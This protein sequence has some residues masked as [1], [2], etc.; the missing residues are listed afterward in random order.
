M[1]E[2]LVIACGIRGEREVGTALRRL[3]GGAG[4]RTDDVGVLEGGEEGDFVGGVHAVRLG[5]LS[6]IDPLHDHQRP[7]RAP[8]HEGGNPKVAAPDDFDSLVAV[9]G[10]RSVAPPTW[11][12]KHQRSAVLTFGA[13]PGP[14]QRAET[15]GCGRW[16]WEQQC[17]G[18]SH[19]PGAWASTRSTRRTRRSARTRGAR[20]KAG[21]RRKRRAE[22]A[23]D[24][25]GAGAAT[26]P[27]GPAPCPP[28]AAPAC[29]TK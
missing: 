29:P 12:A 3:G 17:R 5:H 10:P 22:G 1:H 19:F 26:V 11:A 25:P 15:A 4:A 8:L 7:V 28:T 24:A 2:A 27:P 16:G 9:H 14:V 20:A 6:H 13:C 23:R 18:P 21:S